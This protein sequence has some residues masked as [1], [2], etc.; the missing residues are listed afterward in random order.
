[1]EEETVEAEEE[2]VVL[3]KVLETLPTSKS[4]MVQTINSLLTEMTKDEL[5]F[6]VKHLLEVLTASEKEILEREGGLNLSEVD[7][8][9]M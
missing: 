1:M 9:M 8:L 5:Q 6:K 7:Y 3:E 2:G 4:G